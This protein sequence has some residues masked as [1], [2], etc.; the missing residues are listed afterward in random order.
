MSGSS[1]SHAADDAALGY[2]HQGLF[3]LVVV[4]DSGD[5]SS[6]SIETSGSEKYLLH[7]EQNGKEAFAVPAGSCRVNELKWQEIAENPPLQLV[8][9]PF[10]PRTL[11]RTRTM[12][13]KIKKKLFDRGD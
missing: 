9:S 4:L 12:L 11:L 1:A 5:N 2:Y 3:A 8:R 6:V 7:V 13:A 10:L